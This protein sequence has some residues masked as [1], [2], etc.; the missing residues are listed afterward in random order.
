M[1]LVFWGTPDFAAYILKH[2]VVSSPHQ[3]VGVVTAPDRPAK[4]GHKMTP[5]AVK[6]TALQLLPNTPLLQPE[7][8]RDTSFLD[9]LRS[10]KADIFVVIAFRMLPDIV[11]GMPPKGTFN[12][13]ASLLPAYRGAAP[14]QHCI[15]DGAKE[16]GVTT[17]LLDHQIDTGSILLQRSIPL[18]PEETGGTLHDKLM[19]LGAD[20]V[21]ETLD[22]LESQEDGKSL[23]DPQNLEKEYPLA[24]K[25]FKADRVLS[26]QTNTSEQLHRRIRAM[27]PY[28]SAIAVSDDEETPVEVKIFK[29]ALYSEELPSREFSP[30]SVIITDDRRLLVKTL[31]GV[32]ELLEIQFPG[33]KATL[34]KEFLLGNSFPLRLQ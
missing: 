34:A 32:L 8:L 22:L 10:L 26:F 14:I 3:V 11:W 16:S 31:Q 6:T 17:F 18:A 30:G 24:P 21:I 28:P 13:H 27:A 5:S 15:L 4:R 7:K 25:I 33:K 23:G 9:Q 2:I 20:L 12:L 1:N 19:F 29:S